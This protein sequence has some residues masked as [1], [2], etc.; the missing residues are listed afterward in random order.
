MDKIHLYFYIRMRGGFL[1]PENLDAEAE[2]NCGA[3]D[4]CC[5]LIGNGRGQARA[6]VLVVCKL[7]ISGR[8][9]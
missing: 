7:V 3:P 2:G 9:K 8:I 5:W 1:L 4:R 6:K